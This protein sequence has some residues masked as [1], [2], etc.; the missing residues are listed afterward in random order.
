MLDI[1][2]MVIV[3]GISLF[4]NFKKNKKKK[5][6]YNAWSDNTTGGNNDN[7]VNKKNPVDDFMNGV[8]SF[9]KKVSKSAKSS[10][11]NNNSDGPNFKKALSFLLLGI[12]AIAAIWFSSGF[13][14]VQPDEEGVQ[15][16]LG[17][18]STTSG[19]GLHYHLPYPF[20]D[21]HKVKVTMVNTEEI[22]YRASTSGPNDDSSQV[23]IESTMIT[24]D[25]NMVDVNFDVQWRVNEANQY[26]FNIRNSDISNTIRYAAESVMRD[27]IGRNNMLYALGEGRAIIAEEAKAVLQKILDAYNVGISILSMPIKRIDPPKQVIA[28]FR[29]VQSARADLEREIN[30][31]Q[32]YRN[33]VVPRAKGEA[34]KIINEAESYL[35]VTINKA[36]GETNKMMALYP[37]YQKNPE[38]VKT[39]LYTE[40]MSDVFQDAN[41][42]IIGSGASGSGHSSSGSNLNILNVADLLKTMPGISKAN[43]NNN[44]NGR[45]ESGQK[46]N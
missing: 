40:F 7:Y 33:D 1:V 16:M 10:I 12:G 5:D 22:G 20:A 35:H 44:S 46:D 32:A 27:I 26:I 38:L 9:I 24:R 42:I 19:P 17:K 43:I 25:E 3:A 6:E 41:K 39:R 14:I 2:I 13:Y 29:D 4:I 36:Q 18:Y 11:K 37:L 8:D 23:Y 45:N 31:A 28:A 30:M 34:A 15:V 21:V